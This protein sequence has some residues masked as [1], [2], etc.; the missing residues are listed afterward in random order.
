MSENIIEKH[1]VVETKI[2]ILTEVEETFY[3]EILEDQDPQH[4]RDDYNL[5]LGQIHI[6]SKNFGRITE[7]DGFIPTREKEQDEKQLKKIFGEDSCILPVYMYNHSQISFSTTP[8]SCPWDSGQVGWIGTNAKR[9]ENLGCEASLPKDKEERYEYMKKDLECEIDMLSKWSTGEMY[10]YIKYD[11]DGEEVDSCYGYYGDDF[12][13]NG[14]YEELGLS[15]ET[16]EDFSWEVSRK[17]I[18]K[19]KK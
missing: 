3:I 5:N 6:E 4:P 15:E 7:I 18:R 13:S 10:G 2:E 11:S 19:E 12:V 9:Y 1:V 14:L 16:K 17:P 8:F